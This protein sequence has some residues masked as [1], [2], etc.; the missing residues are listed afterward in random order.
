MKEYAIAKFPTPLL[1]RADFSYVFGGASQGVLL[2]KKGLLNSLEMIAFPGQIFTV[3]Q[4]P[5]AFPYIC[6]VKLT[7]YPVENPIYADERFLEYGKKEFFSSETSKMPS[8]EEILASLKGM[9][10]L[11][12]IWGG[13]YSQGIEWM[14]DLYPPQQSHPLS[15][16]HYHNWVFKGVDCSGML[17]EA[18]Q[19]LTP[20]NTSW[21]ASYG[22]A[23]LI[24]GLTE[25][26]ILSLLKPLDMIV[27]HG[28]VLYVLDDHYTIE[29]RAQRGCVFKTPIAERLMQIR[30]EE[31][32]EPMNTPKNLFYKEKGFVVR[33]WHPSLS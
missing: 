29:S 3:V 17:Y 30:V 18:T 24:E 1:N 5:S 10:G 31:K 20:R 25:E 32:K 4:K 15:A 2:D 28:H 13:N 12:Y 22:E 33:R 8:M 7:S 19:G 14:L 16:V 21:L 26:K 9:L 6:E 11:P 27:W 23:I